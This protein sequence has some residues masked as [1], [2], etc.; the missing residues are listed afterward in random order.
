MQRSA[1]ISVIRVV[2]VV[3]AALVV[4]CMGNAVVAPAAPQ[5][6]TQARAE[7]LL[8]AVRA[9]EREQVVREAIRDVHVCKTS[10]GQGF[11]LAAQA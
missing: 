3:W 11:S 9:V 7:E 4:T 2:H 6:Q 8:Q 10:V 1:P 5:T